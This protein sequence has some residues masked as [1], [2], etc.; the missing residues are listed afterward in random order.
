MEFSW[1]LPY[2][3]GLVILIVALKLLTLPVKLI[4]KFVINAIVGGAL[5]FIINAVGVEF[6]YAITL[7]WLTGIIVG[8]LGVPGVIVA[9]ILQAIL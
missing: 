4:I 5:I 8:I 9:A 6:G 1:I 7:N 3:V 2:L